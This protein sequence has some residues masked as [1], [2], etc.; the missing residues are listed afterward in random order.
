MNSAGS[1]TQRLEF[2]EAITVERGHAS[3]CALRLNIGCRGSVT[4]SIANRAGCPDA[5]NLLSVSLRRAK[6]DR[7]LQQLGWPD[8]TNRNSVAVEVAASQAKQIDS[9]FARPSPR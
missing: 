2:S 6:D 3:I 8:E 5:D 4:G 7:P 9:R 1:K